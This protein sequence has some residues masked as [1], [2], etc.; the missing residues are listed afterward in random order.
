M[1]RILSFLLLMLFTVAVAAC[2]TTTTTRPTGT[3]GTTTTTTTTSSQSQTASVSVTTG[4]TT[5]TT[6]TT[7]TTT[8][9][10]LDACGVDRSGIAESEFVDLE[11][12]SIENQEIEELLLCE[13]QRQNP[14]IRVTNRPDILAMS[15][16]ADNFTYSIVSL[17]AIGDIP[18]VF[19]VMQIDPLVQNLL[20]YDFSDLWNADPDTT[21]VLPGAA[22]AA[23]YGDVR[24][25]MV[26]GQVMQGIFVN[27][28][29]LEEN[30]FDLED[31]GFD[32]ATGEIWNYQQMIQLARDFTT[33]ARARYDNNF[34]WGI[35]GD[36]N[37]L[38]F[39]WVLPAMDNLA[40]GLNSF[41]GSAF[42]FA[43]PLYIDHFQREISLFQEGVKVDIKKDP[44]G[45]QLE[46][47]STSPDLF[48]TEG[49]V[50]LYSSYTWNFD[51]IATSPQNLMF[52]PFPKG[53]G[54]NA[55]ARTP[56]AIG[57]LA[58]SN[59]T[60]HPEEAYQLAKFMSWG[61]AGQL[62]KI[63]IHRSRG[64]H[65]TKFPV[66]DFASVWNQIEQV[67]IDSESPLYV[68]GF[69]MIMYPLLQTKQAVM[70][71][72]KWL[73]GYSEFKN[74]YSYVQ[75]ESRRTD[76][77]NGLILFADVA[78]TWET[79]ANSLVSEKLELYKRYPNLS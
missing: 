35:D 42:H 28:D 3:T 2:G 67:Y 78:Q 44:A 51:M 49:R 17:A 31:Y 62:A 18:D 68:E 4:T 40:W 43:D 57:I 1:K 79:K 23:L 46:F 30:N 22:T 10:G 41:D 27:K 72:G 34:Y 58:L 20:V 60:E 14:T 73:P 19:A 7:T 66:A 8:S 56:S 32:F 33:R 6:T 21:H 59:T 61:E 52:L 48:F 9:G 24:L 29:L 26:N 76:V 64:E 13:F 37:N 74:W 75:T 63:A 25:G 71:F 45:A 69:D 16:V 15:G 50:L 12:A 77:L 39:A 53:V 38:N 54:E 47:G 70:D 5:A 65:L 55:V 11:Y 36:W